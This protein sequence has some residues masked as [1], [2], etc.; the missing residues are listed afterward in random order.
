MS[1]KFE[2]SETSNNIYL[3]GIASLVILLPPKNQ[4]AYWLFCHG[5]NSGRR[6]DPRFDLAADSNFKTRPVASAVWLW[7]R[8]M[9]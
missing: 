5:M 3:L 1:Y 6:A 8:V 7:V 9:L 2:N 4:P